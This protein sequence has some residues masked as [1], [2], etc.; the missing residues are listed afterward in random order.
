M[1]FF[2]NILFILVVMMLID[3]FLDTLFEDVFIYSIT[4]IIIKHVK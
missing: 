4:I 3:I 2:F 1:P